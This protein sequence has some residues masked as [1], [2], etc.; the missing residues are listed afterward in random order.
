VVVVVVV[1]VVVG[2][3]QEGLLGAGSSWLIGGRGFEGVGI[4]TMCALFRSKRGV[5]WEG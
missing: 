4:E 3:G 5:C 1:V 2:S